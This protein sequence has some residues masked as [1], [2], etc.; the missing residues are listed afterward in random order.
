MYC[1]PH[2]MPRER[3][4]KPVAL[5]TMLCSKLILEL[6]GKLVTIAA[7]LSPTLGKA[8]LRGRVT[9][10][11][12]KAL[13]IP[14][15]ARREAKAFD[16]AIKVHLHARLV[17]L[18]AG[19]DHAVLVGI[20]LEDGA[21]GGIELGVH[22]HDVL[23]VLEGLEHDVGTVFDRAGDIDEHV[24]MRRACE[25]H[26]ILGRHRPR[27]RGSIVEFEPRH[28]DDTVLAARKFEDRNGSLGTPVR[29]CDDT[30]TKR[31]VDDL[32]GQASIRKTN[33][34]RKITLLSDTYSS[35][36]CR[37][38]T[39]WCRLEKFILFLV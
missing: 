1:R 20:G 13:H 14:H 2:D 36:I 22:Q 19:E 32:V 28:R 37:N 30:H 5:A 38:T 34:F 31:A 10:R 24:D 18:T 25:E 15:Q 35:S 33:R 9:I 6:S 3:T 27:A 7:F 23:P 29:Y 39:Y 17:A 16:P 11:V 4:L 21:D 26:R 12:L 8:V